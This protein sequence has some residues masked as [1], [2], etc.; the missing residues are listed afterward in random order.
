MNAGG[1]LIMTITGIG[2]NV[3]ANECCDL[4]PWCARKLVRWSAFHRYTDPARAEARAEELV[5][6][7]DDRPGHT[8]KLITALGFAGCAAFASARRLLTRQHGPAREVKETAA[9]TAM[10][11]HRTECTYVLDRVYAYLDGDLDAP[12]MVRIR[13]HLDECGPCL[14]EYGLDEVVKQLVHKHTGDNLVPHVLR[15]KVLARIQQVK[16][17]LDTQD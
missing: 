6:L 4:A 8:L 11:V 13:S 14:A 7:I 10:P 2:L 17:E 16:N 1:I 9:A 15:D 12:D 3:V 5:A